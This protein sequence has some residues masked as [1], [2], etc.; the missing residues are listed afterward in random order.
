MTCD[1]MTM[2]DFLIAK[3]AETAGV[4]ILYR[5][6]LETDFTRRVRDFLRDECEPLF[7]DDMADEWVWQL[8]DLEAAY[9]AAAEAA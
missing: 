7:V 5:E 9:S 2:T 1:E 8:D 6:Q 4:E 3:A